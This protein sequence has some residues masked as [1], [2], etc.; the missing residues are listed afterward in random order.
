VNLPILEI[1]DRLVFGLDHTLELEPSRPV[2]LVE[3]INGIGG[4]GAGR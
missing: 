1:W 2:R 3:V 4:G